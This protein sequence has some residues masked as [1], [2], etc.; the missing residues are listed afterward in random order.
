M[1]R[2]DDN[3]GPEY[4]PELNELFEA[5]P[6][7]SEID[8]RGADRLVVRL[9]H[10]GFFAHR[11]GVPSVARDL[12]F[13]WRL[14]IAAAAALVL[15]A[16]SAWGGFAAGRRGS[17]EEMLARTDLTVADRVL[18]LQRA[19]S[20]YVSAAQSYANATART[21]TTAIE[22]ASR[23]L[24]GAAHAVARNHLDA[25]VAARLT[26]ALQPTA[27]TTRPTIWF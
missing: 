1:E 12:L 20:A 25:G 8:P 13:S 2:D 21:D 17:L 6:R 14:P 26:N 18:L 3:L 27:P 11:T 10:D 15:M 9:N 19:G 5:L 7:A 24:I 22:V 16:L 4:D 23:V